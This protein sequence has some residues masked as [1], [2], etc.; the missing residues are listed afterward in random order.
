VPKRCHTSQQASAS[1]SVPRRPSAN[2]SLPEALQPV[3][4]TPHSAMI[5]AITTSAPR[6]L[7][8]TVQTAAAISRLTSRP[9]ALVC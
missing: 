1:S 6:L 7:A 9:L 3:R 5:S 2:H 8:I 4:N